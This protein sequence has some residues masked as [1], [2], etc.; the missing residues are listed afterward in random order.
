[1]NEHLI[2]LLEELNTYGQAFIELESGAIISAEVDDCGGCIVFEL[3]P[4]SEGIY[5]RIGFRDVANLLSH[6][7]IKEIR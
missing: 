5:D 7:S 2:E 1:M 3:A 4:E 6:N